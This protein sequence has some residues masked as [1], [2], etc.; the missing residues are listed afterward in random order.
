MIT[1]EPVIEIYITHECNLTCSNCNRYNNYNFSGHFYW[2][3]QKD[4]LSAWSKRITAPLITLIGGEPSLHPE[5]GKWLMNVSELWPNSNIMIQTNG[6]KRI[7][8]VMED[9]PAISR[10]SNGRLGQGIAVHSI[11]FYPKFRQFV[12]DKTMFDATEFSECAL[13]DKGSHFEVHD[14]NPDFAYESCTMKVSHTL[15]NGLLYKCPM[16]AILPEFR[17]QYDVRLTDKQEELL[18]SYKPLH[19]SCSDEELDA[20]VDMTRVSIPQCN[21]CPEQYKTS[22]VKFNPSLKKRK[23]LGE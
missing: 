13:V 23:K 8:T 11:D 3:Q 6:V 12:K 19:P 16:V 9:F 5:I 1:F 7:P 14:S 10:E 22:T 4:L 2:D 18:S 20:F 17:K 21:L 15:F